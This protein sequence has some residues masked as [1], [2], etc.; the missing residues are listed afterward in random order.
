[1]RQN[2][3]GRQFFITLL[4]TSFILPVIVAVLGI[5][6]IWGR[7][8]LFSDMLV[9][10]G[11][12]PLNI[13]GMTGIILAHVFFNLPLATRLVLQG[14]ISV[15]TEHFRLC[16][17]LGMAPRDVLKHLE[18][19]ILR[20]VLPPAFLTIFLLCITSFAVAL[21]LG[22]GP[23]ATTVELAIFQALRFDFD[24]PKAALFATFQFMLCTTIALLA[25]SFAKTT[26]FST[27]LGR[28]AE[29]WDGQNRFH[30]YSDTGL[31]TLTGLFLFLPLAAILF[32]GIQHLPKLPASVI[33]ASMNSI[34]I[35][36]GSATI[37]IGLALTISCLIVRL[38]QNNKRTAYLVESIGFLSLVASP[39]VI[40]T[41]LFIIIFPF[42]SPFKLALPIT[43]L[44]NAIMALPFAIRIILPA[45]Q[46][47]E[48][49]YGRLADSLGMSQWLRFRLAIWPHL[50]PSTGFAMGLAAALSMGDLGVIALFASPDSATLP[51]IMYRLM[52]SYQT[53][54]ASAVA[55][56]LIAISLGLFWIF[57]K[58]GRIE[59]RI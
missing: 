37:C 47:A 45:M 3:R 21:T 51:L 55:L 43:A 39:F 9:A 31:L 27:G 10:I 11:Q 35:S 14:W 6:A 23:R 28:P 4:G 33:S 41:G 12:P 40:G 29:R 57:D 17:Q 52:A 16:A 34:M 26:T 8:G 2:F 53:E 49:G 56:M 24:L 18:R 15:P 48:A 59:H 5:L 25:L 32:K 44:V 20:A 19:P 58:G 13:Y 30:K 38:T 42:A 1:A 36:L 50:K 54:A 46:R 22:G 7:S